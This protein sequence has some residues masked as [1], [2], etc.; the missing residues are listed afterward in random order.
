M[1]GSQLAATKPYRHSNY[2]VVTANKLAVARYEYKSPEVTCLVKDRYQVTQDTVTFVF[3]FGGKNI[4]NV[5][6]SE[7]VYKN[8]ISACEEEGPSS[9]R[10]F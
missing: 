8:Q 3:T 4:A 10:G 2:S 6:E 1:N 7:F 5:L 9:S